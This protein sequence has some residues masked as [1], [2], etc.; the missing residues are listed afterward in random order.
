MKA[1]V[2]AWQNVCSGATQGTPTLLIPIGKTFMLQ[3]VVFQGPCIST[4]V[5]IK[6][7]HN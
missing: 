3:P 7:G 2:K 1:F 5:N 4:N 6:V